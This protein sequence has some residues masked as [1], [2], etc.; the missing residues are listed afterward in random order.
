MAT[1][2]STATA[3]PL[4]LDL[5]Y[6]NTSAI[7]NQMTLL[8]Q[9][10]LRRA[11]IDLT[12]RS[13]D[14]PIYL[15]RRAAGRLRHRFLR[16]HAGSFSVG[17]HPGLVVRRRDERRPLLRPTSRL[18]D[19]AA[20]ASAG[21]ARAAWHGVLRQIEDD[22]PAAFM[23]APSYVYAV[24]RRF[25]NVTIRPESSWIALWKWTVGAPANR[26]DAGY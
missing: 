11:G 7:R 16:D 10:Q 15:E 19:R 5:S 17:S 4:R 24:N 20:I 21:D 1:A 12:V 8:A 23:Y 2:F 9:Q 14:Y 26:H 3:V 13:Y 25:E 22:A 18:A 6:P